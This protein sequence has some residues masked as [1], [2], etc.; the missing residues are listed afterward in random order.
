MRTAGGVGFADACRPDRPALRVAAE[1][2]LGWGACVLTDA[3]RLA[4]ASGALCLE[5]VASLVVQC[6]RVAYFLT[7]C[8][9]LQPELRGSWHTLV[10]L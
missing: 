3:G 4:G 7:W 1:A 9:L 10:H 5:L 2:L 6:A 8:R